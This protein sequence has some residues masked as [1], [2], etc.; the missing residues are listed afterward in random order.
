MDTRSARLARRR[1]IVV[2]AMVGLDHGFQTIRV[3][4]KGP[5]SRKEAGCMV[6]LVRPRRTLRVAAL[7]LL[8]AGMLPGCAMVPRERLDES[9]RLAQSLR[10]ENARLKDQVLGLQA[11]NQDYA[12]RALD[13]LRRLTA[14]DEAIERLEQSVQAYQDDRDRLAGAYRRL[15]V[16]L[17]RTTEDSTPESTSARRGSASISMQAALADPGVVRETESLTR[18][19]DEDADGERR[20]SS[21]NGS[22]P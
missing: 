11:Q 8:A 2:E 5:D 21:A 20:R 22:G 13:D 12:D 1:P 15:A 3:A 14:R 18:Q 4:S 9:Q 10:T 7:P 16:S 17:G 19:D 6:E